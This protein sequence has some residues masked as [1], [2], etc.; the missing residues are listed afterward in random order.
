MNLAR[1]LFGA[2]GVPP[3]SDSPSSGSGL[4]EAAL[5]LEAPLAVLGPIDAS[6]DTLAST[7]ASRPRRTQKQTLDTVKV[8]STFSP[9]AKALASGRA[10]SR[11]RVEEESPGDTIPTAWDLPFRSD[12]GSRPQTLATQ[13]R[14]LS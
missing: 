4:R 1:F 8:H 14:E 6:L 11:A 2:E 12:L 9:G 10:D 7:S 5:D 13:L 3:D